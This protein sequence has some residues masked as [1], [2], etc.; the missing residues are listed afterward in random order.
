M[1]VEVLKGE[2]GVGV[3]GGIKKWDVLGWWCS[4]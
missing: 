3:S 4:S 2:N 1:G